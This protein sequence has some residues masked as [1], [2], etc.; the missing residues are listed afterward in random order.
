MRTGIRLSLI[1][2][3]SYRLTL[4]SKKTTPSERRKSNI[5][6]L[7]ETEAGAGREVVTL[8]C[9]ASAETE[10]AD[11]VVEVVH[12]QVEGVAGTDHRELATTG[13]DW[14]KKDCGF[15]TN[16]RFQTEPPLRLL[17]GS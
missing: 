10:H 17:R 2:Q 1:I 6:S 11:D 13:E 5:E 4:N 16:R 9:N 8:E 3:H 7:V 14:Y 15:E 12:D